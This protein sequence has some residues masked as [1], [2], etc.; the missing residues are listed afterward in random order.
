MPG[1][2]YVRRKLSDFPEEGA[3]QLCHDGWEGSHQVETTERREVAYTEASCTKEQEVGQW[4]R[5]GALIA[6]PWM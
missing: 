1:T 5:D 4:P 3:S 6:M 2:G